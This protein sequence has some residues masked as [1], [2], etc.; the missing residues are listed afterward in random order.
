MLRGTREWNDYQPL[1]GLFGLR[2]ILV[3]SVFT[4]RLLLLLIR[5]ACLHV[6]S[7]SHACPRLDRSFCP[8]SPSYS[9]CC[10]PGVQRTL[11]RWEQVELWDQGN[12][13]GEH[14]EL[15]TVF[16][17]PRFSPLFRF[18]VEKHPAAK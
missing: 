2:Q 14:Q 17:A 8:F 4:P 10:K 18:Q 13:Y 7:G 12:T 16:S 15:F 11:E 5:A 6:G 9:E 1:P 3:G